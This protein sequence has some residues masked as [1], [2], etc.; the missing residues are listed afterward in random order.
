VSRLVSSLTLE[1][2]EA[3]YHFKASVEALRILIAIEQTP[4]CE[5]VRR[6]PDKIDKLDATARKAWRQ[7]NID[8]LS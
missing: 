7:R 2:K 5:L 1:E 4:T 8:R 3:E 6:R